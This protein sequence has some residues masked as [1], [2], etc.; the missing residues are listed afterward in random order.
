MIKNL[1]PE[2]YKNLKEV[3]S[4]GPREVLVNLNTVKFTAD[5]SCPVLT[6]L[7][8][9]EDLIIDI[10]DARSGMDAIPGTE[11]DDYIDDAEWQ[12]I[13]SKLTEILDKNLISYLKLNSDLFKV[14]SRGEAGQA[15]QYFE[16]EAIYNRNDKK[17]LYWNQR[18]IVD[19][20]PETEEET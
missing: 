3:F 15:K 9:S 18:F 20:E 13:S 10:R 17:I 4:C 19:N 1:T 2:N 14:V 16:I 11:D 12:D 6:T 7:G 8:L 5:G